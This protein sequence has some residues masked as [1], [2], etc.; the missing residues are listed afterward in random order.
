MFDSLLNDEIPDVPGLKPG[1]GRKNTA[2]AWMRFQC[3]RH[4][5]AITAFSSAAVILIAVASGLFIHYGQSGNKQ[6]ADDIIPAEGQVV[7]K[8]SSGESIALDTV[9]DGDTRLL[10]DG[11]LLDSESSELNY[12]FT[13]PSEELEFHELTLSKGKSHSV[14]LSDG[15][16]VFLNSGSTLRYPVAFGEDSRTVELSGEAYFDVAREEKRPF[17]VHTSRFD[18]TVKGTAFD[19]CAYEEDP[20]ATT[21]L[22]RGSVG[23]DEVTLEPGKQFRKDVVS[24]ESNVVEVD[25]EEYTCWKDNVMILR[26]TAMDNIMKKLQKRYDFDYELSEAASKEN[27]SGNLPLN[28]NLSVILDQLCAVSD[29]SFSIE[30]GHVRVE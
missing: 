28:E 14:T 5:Q 17:V 4:S 21:T 19:V 23:V 25:T 20:T 11:V 27:F 7:L 10:K 24:G 15:T 29:L 16:R 2:R 1:Y 8:L 12:S 30:K 22:V 13:G 18:V 6:L 26:H 9:E 3:H